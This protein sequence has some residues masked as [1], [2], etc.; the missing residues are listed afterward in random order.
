M[1]EKLKNQVE[2]SLS[3]QETKEETKD[4]ILRSKQIL[5]F[6]KDKNPELYKQAIKEYDNVK[7]ITKA[8]LL[9]DRKI[10]ETELENIKKEFKDVKKLDKRDVWEKTSDFIAR[11]IIKTNDDIVQSWWA[12]F[13][14]HVDK[15]LDLVVGQ[16]Q[17]DIEAIRD[18]NES[19]YTKLFRISEKLRQSWLGYFDTFIKAHDNAT[20]EIIKW[21]INHSK[22]IVV[23]S[24][25]E[26]T[27]YKVKNESDF[28]NEIKGKPI[29]QI[30]KKELGTYMCA[31][32]AR[33]QLTHNK[34]KET[35]WIENTIYITQMVKNGDFAED[36]KEDINKIYQ[37][38]LD[39][40]NFIGN[41]KN[42]VKNYIEKP[43]TNIK[44]IENTIKNWLK[45]EKSD[46]KMYTEEI[47]KE[48]E[49]CKNI[50]N[51]KYSDI[52]DFDEKEEWVDTLK[53]AQ[54]E[55]YEAIIKIKEIHEQWIQKTT[56][57]IL[58]EIPKKLQDKET[59][60]IIQETSKIVYESSIEN[61]GQRTCAFKLKTHIVNHPKLE[62]L[63]KFLQDRHKLNI[64]LKNITQSLSDNI[65]EVNIEEKKEK[66]TALKER[67]KYWEDIITNEKTSQGEKKEAKQKLKEIELS[68][69]L[70]QEDIVEAERI[71]AV[72]KNTTVEEALEFQRMIDSWKS[73]EEAINE[74]QKNNPKLQKIFQTYRWSFEKH[75][76]IQT[77][78]LSSIT[79]IDGN[80]SI[81][82]KAGDKI[83]WLDKEEIAIINDPKNPEALNNLIRFHN[84]F[85]SINMLWVW[86]YRKD[87]VTAMEDR[88]INL[89]D[90]SLSEDE[91]VRFWN[92]LIKVINKLPNSKW[93]KNDTL[94]EQTNID[95]VKNELKRYSEADSEIND[96]KT[97]NNLWEDKFTTQLRNA[98]I[99]DEN[100]WFKREK[101]NSYLS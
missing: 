46:N 23:I 17:K 95:W 33:K 22:E 99:I 11:E 10:T 84:F 40:N 86:K 34:L 26:T 1:S 82:T 62:Q 91:I 77:E 98:G 94:N 93:V 9:N 6:L 21:I 70:I 24:H 19:I 97:F 83:S 12:S 61:L 15:M 5:D 78:E 55:L 87:L 90:N 60:K 58:K 73:R 14:K 67:K 100:L 79:L 38:A 36:W 2:N 32:S 43:N 49:I 28:L 92:N 18:S 75:I 39:E 50:H 57:T 29:T 72:S 74:I 56:E 51:L 68:L 47:I 27:W 31:L 8:A 16:T 89:D 41:M 3:E 37:E 88:N 64:D 81:Q 13:H 48:C 65:T 7:N 4:I 101:F 63:K 20:K 45:S 96:E 25:D 76:P 44:N 53:K 71:H 85:K 59:L 69:S 30:N 80:Y 42:I 54:P 52:K 35:F 66:Q